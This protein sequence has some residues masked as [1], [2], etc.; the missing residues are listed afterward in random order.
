[1]NKREGLTTKSQI[2]EMRQELYNAE[3]GIKT[4]TKKKWSKKKLA[5]VLVMAVLIVACSVFAISA[6]LEKAKGNAVSIFGTYF[7]IVETESMVP[8]LL[9]ND[10]FASKK[11]NENTPLEKGD[12]ITFKT[13]SN[14]RVT[15]RIYEVYK[16]DGTVYYK[17]KGDNKV[18]GV[19]P[20]AL[21]R[22]DIEGV[23]WFKFPSISPR[24]N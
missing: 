19:D 8:T 6:T 4:A 2:E 15:H 24:K 10:I 16:T 23:F 13:A 20:W 7:F 14:Q 22:E 5:N 12:I 3:N 17:T 9:V 1:M 18:N 21:T 11:V